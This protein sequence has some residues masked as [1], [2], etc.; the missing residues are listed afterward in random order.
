MRDVFS[1]PFAREVF[2][3]LSQEFNRYGFRFDNRFFNQV[4]FGGKGVV[5]GGLFFFGPGGFTRTFYDNIFNKDIVTPVKKST[6]QRSLIGKIGEKAAAFLLKKIFSLPKNNE[7]K[8]LY[9]WLAITPEEA[10]TGT[11]KQIAVKRRGKLE[12]FLV[13]I[14][15]GLNP[16]TYLRLK[17]KG[18]E[19]DMGNHSG[20]LFLHIVTKN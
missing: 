2:Q 12:K 5:F 15:P 11:E 9:Y 14:P 19:S 10:A 20:D 17:G 7:E 3:D 1:N 16:G 6:Q 13:K 18:K 4:F 8:N